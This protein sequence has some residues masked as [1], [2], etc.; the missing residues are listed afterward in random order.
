[1]NSS[2]NARLGRLATKLAKV[3]TSCLHALEQ[4]LEVLPEAPPLQNVI[5][6]KLLRHYAERDPQSFYQLDAFTQVAQDDVFGPDDEGDCVM[7]GVTQELM[8]GTYALRVLITSGTTKDEA[9]RLLSK[10]VDAI[11]SDVKERLYIGAQ[12]PTPFEG[13]L[14]DDFWEGVMLPAFGSESEQN[15]E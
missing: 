8:T 15:L 1:M 11:R 3:D 12:Y 7:C 4:L 6:Q 2:D 10:V 14:P 13:E 5:K 9:V